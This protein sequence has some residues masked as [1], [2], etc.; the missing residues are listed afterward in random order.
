MRAL[1]V[2]RTKEKY[3]N[4]KHHT[5]PLE[6]PIRILTA[7]YKNHGDFSIKYFDY[8]DVMTAV[9]QDVTECLGSAD[10]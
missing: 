2:V 10:G 1:A 6:T 5:V 7:S 8:G 4:V 9:R 3:V